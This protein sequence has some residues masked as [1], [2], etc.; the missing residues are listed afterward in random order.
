MHRREILRA[1]SGAAAVSVLGPLT[2]GQRFRLGRALHARL[3]PG[4][5][6]TLNARHAVLVT[7]LAETIL[8]RTDTPGA[9]DVRV[10]EFVDLLLTEWYSSA[11]RARLL[12]G[13]AA[14]DANMQREGGM[15]AAVALLDGTGGP[16]E[17]ASGAYQRL[18]GHVIHGYF[19]SREVQ[20]GVLRTVIIPGRFDGCATPDAR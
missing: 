9:T 10:A 6:R 11:E 15:A 20:T 4:V 8:P 5:F 17:S 3:R 13:I 7:E 16:P 14:I 2:A 19:T 12:T 1:L 18:K